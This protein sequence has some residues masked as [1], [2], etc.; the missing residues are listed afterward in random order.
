MEKSLQI[1]LD[2]IELDNFGVLEKDMEHLR[3]LET[4]TGKVSIDGAGGTRVYMIHIKDNSVFGDLLIGCNQYGNRRIHY[5]SLSLTPTNVR[6]HNCDNLT[7]AEYDRYL[8]YVMTYIRRKYRIHLKHD[9]KRIKYMEINCNIS[10]CAPYTEY[11][12]SVRLMMSF[13]PKTLRSDYVQRSNPK[14][15]DNTYLRG[16]Q[17]MAVTI[18]NKSAQMRQKNPE[19]KQEEPGDL[20]RLELRLKDPQKI[21][22]ALGSSVWARLN[23]DVIKEWYLSYVNQKI[24]VKYME[25]KKKRR[26]ELTRLIRELRNEQ[27]KTWHHL[28]MQHV[29]NRSEAAGVPYILDVEQ[30]VEALYQLPDPHGNHSRARKA[31]MGIR[32][33]NDLY[34][35]RDQARI[36]EI[37]NWFASSA[38]QPK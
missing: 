10:L 8:Q 11:D 5:T 37:L 1:G 26:N 14:K 20:L 35:R 32:I 24:A 7:W 2:K 18:Y 34:H 23:D 28:T 22:S 9:N 19:Y 21:E 3:T 33:E 13:L 6:G 27:P 29:R 36:E 15:D 12:R 30:V 4:M 17:R 31:L 38:E 25:W 16:N